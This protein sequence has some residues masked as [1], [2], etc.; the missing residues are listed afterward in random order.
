MK[1]NS[2]NPKELL[3]E[4]RAIHFAMKKGAITYEKA[5]ELTKPILADVNTRII[6]I[7]NKYGQ[8]P[9]LLKF[10]DLGRNL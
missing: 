4:A 6:A 1:H 7:A 10:Q 9:K 2:L 3:A 5:K 8:R